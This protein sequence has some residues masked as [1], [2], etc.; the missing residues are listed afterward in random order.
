MARKKTTGFQPERDFSTKIPFWRVKEKPER[1]TISSVL[2]QSSNYTFKSK[3]IYINH[4]TPRTTISRNGL[5]DNRQLDDRPEHL[6]SALLYGI[7]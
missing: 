1:N 3:Q 6:F 5:E 7:T 4:V 2:T